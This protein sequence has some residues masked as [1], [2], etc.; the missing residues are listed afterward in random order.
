MEDTEVP[1][2]YLIKDLITVEEEQWLLT[3]TEQGEWKDNRTGS[4]QVQI[5]GPYHDNKYKII[6]GQYSEHPEWISWLAQRVHD[7]ITDVNRTKLLGNETCE[8]YINKYVDDNGLQ[9]HFDNRKTYDDCIYGISMGND[10]FMGF[11]KGSTKFK[12][13]VPARSMYIMSGESRNVYKHGIDYGWITGKRISITFR[14]I[15]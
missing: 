4:R 1:G 3:E 7:R 6:P 15:R 13:G 9:Y 12:I 2:L 10:A 11:K 8:V 5:Y 14:T